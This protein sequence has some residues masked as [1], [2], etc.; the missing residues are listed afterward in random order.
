MTDPRR[1]SLPQPSGF[2][3]APLGGIV[4]WIVAWMGWMLV[5]LVGLVFIASVLIW[6][7][8]LIAFSL[9]RGWITGRPSTVALLWRHY[10]DLMRGRWP[11]TPGKKRS[12][13]PRADAVQ[14]TT[15]DDSVQDVNWRDVSDKENS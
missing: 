3:A 13:T 10:R 2:S 9:I 6:L 4:G 12:T 11:Q 1:P 15:A 7:L 14:A 8:V 5:A